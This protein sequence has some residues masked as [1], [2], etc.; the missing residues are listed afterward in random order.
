MGQPMSGQPPLLG[1]DRSVLYSRLKTFD[2]QLVDREHVDREHV[3]REHVDSVHVAII[4]H[5]LPE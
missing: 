2:S 3:D 1:P 4:S 5:H